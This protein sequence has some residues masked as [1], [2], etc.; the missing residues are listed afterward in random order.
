MRRFYLIVPLLF[1]AFMTG[2]GGSSGGGGGT[3]VETAVY[4][5]G[6]QTESLTLAYG[7]PA[8]FTILV[9]DKSGNPL[10]GLDVEVVDENDTLQTPLFVR[11]GEDGKADVNVSVKA[12][13]VNGTGGTL[14]F[15]VYTEDPSLGYGT[16]FAFPYAVAPWNMELWGGE[17][18]VRV[19]AYAG[20]KG[21]AVYEVPDGVVLIPAAGETMASGVTFTV[22]ETNVTVAYDGDL[23]SMD[24]NGSYERS[25][26]V[27]ERNDTAALKVNLLVGDGTAAAPMPLRTFDEL[28]AVLPGNTTMSYILT[29]DIAM[30]AAWTPVDFNGSFDG[31]GFTVAFAG[32]P[33]FKKLSSATVENLALTGAVSGYAGLLSA[34]ATGTTFKHIT[35]DEE[36]SLYY[37]CPASNTATSYAGMLGGTVGGTLEDITLDG[38]VTLGNCMYGYAGMAA[39][40]LSGTASFITAKGSVNATYLAMYNIGG[41]AGSMNGTLTDSYGGATFSTTTAAGSSYYI[42]MG[43]LLGRVPESTT[44]TIERCFSD[45]A[46]SGNYYDGGLVGFA[47]GATTIYDSYATG[48]ISG[49]YLGGIIGR[50][51]TQGS[52][53]HTIK[54]TYVTGTITGSGQTVGGIWGS[55]IGTPTN[56][57]YAYDNLVLSKTLTGGSDSAR[58]HYGIW[59]ESN[60][61][62]KDNYAYS[63]MLVNGATRSSAD[64][65]DPDGADVMPAEL[66][67]AFFT[68]TLGWDPAVWDFD[69]DSR[70]Y[71]LPILKSHNVEVQ[72]ALPMPE[73]LQ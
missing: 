13:S 26:G 32:A 46:I 53:V 59:G 5:D 8:G 51:Y 18:D 35:T 14:S 15:V 65:E 20:L 49:A 57:S 60:V 62:G 37:A 21:E 16:S 33:L 64:D 68:E 2:C 54:R 27:A 66:T 41:I 29:G 19:P 22:N 70:D 50:A 31:D 17:I 67:E 28:N 10:S 43:G 39:G 72:K 36:S 55:A 69:F 3:S 71:K 63:E 44:I 7:T 45:S 23:I 1:V 9:T 30:D 56:R 40:S 4:A 38:S 47:Y 52:A 48:N 58:I 11:T 61:A 6:T 25:I 12:V 73:H 42:I 34:S 24:G